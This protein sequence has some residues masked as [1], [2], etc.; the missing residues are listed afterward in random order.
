MNRRKFLASAFAASLAAPSTRAFGSDA[1]KKYYPQEWKQFRIVTRVTLPDVPGPAQLWLPLAQTASDYQVASA[2]GLSDEDRAKVVRDARYGVPV[3]RASWE[4]K[5]RA[6]RHLEVEQF[7]AVRDRATASQMM[8][9]LTEA[10]RRFWTGPTATM[11]LDGI[12]LDTAAKITAGRDTPRERLR[13]IYDWVVEHTHRDPDVPGCGRGEIKTMLDKGEFGG[14]C[15]DINGLM[16]GLARAA[17]FPAREVYGIRAAPSRLF[18]SLGVS[19]DVSRAQHC[20]AEV[21]L[22]GTGWLPVDPADVRKVV[23]QDKIPLD[24]GEV[25]SLRD[26]L[27]GNWEMNWIG[28]N[29]A[30]DIEL[31]G[32]NGSQRPEFAFLMYP[33]AFTSDGSC[34]C[35][36]PDAFPIR[37]HLV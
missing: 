26:Q 21:F 13:A 25:R 15:A 35:T 8:L 29:S 22:D 4:E 32:A 31:P 12:V 23:L 27:F 18:P 3:L 11:P 10:E 28:Y 34:P 1:P 24:S 5:D 36:D 7:V 20:R 16:V 9:P 6:P 17:G 19:G 30:M 14:K 37:D 2:P 33:C